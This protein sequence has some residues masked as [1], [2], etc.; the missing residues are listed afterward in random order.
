MVKS[1]STARSLTTRPRIPLITTGL[2]L[3]IQFIEDATKGPVDIVKG[4]WEGTEI[5]A[6]PS[7]EGCCPV[8][9]S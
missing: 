5:L 2:G 1:R 4:D 9:Q 3:G 6:A 8:G 7:P